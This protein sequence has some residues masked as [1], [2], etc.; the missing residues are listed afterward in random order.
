MEDLDLLDKKIMYELDIDARM[1][2]SQLAKKLRKSK[3][4]INFRI[5]RLIKSDYLKGF[6]TVFNT[7]A[8]GWFYV[9]F[10]F[11]FR[12]IT[13][14]K[15][16]ELFE[17]I[18]KQ[19]HIAYLGSVEGKY[20]CIL[21]VMVKNYADLSEF[22]DRFM[23][24]YGSF[25]R[26][27]DIVTFLT[28]HRL[29]ERFLFEGN[30]KKDWSYPIKLENYTLD[31]LDKKILKE[32][33]TNART[34][35][36]EI[37][38]RL[39][40]DPKVIN[41]RLKKLEKDRIILAYVTA[42]NFDKLGKSFFQVNISLEDPT[43]RPTVIEFFN[44]TNKCLYAIEIMGKY[45]LLVE[46]HLDGTAELKSLLDSFREKFVN[47]YSDYDVLTVSKEHVVVWSPFE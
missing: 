7:S 3:E 40:T 4:T 10:Y 18:S 46:L 32:I 43:Q 36:V 41:Y 12:S 21:L 47:V 16:K 31:K 24:K 27:K 19:N 9:K 5:N 6:Y 29:N 42:P 45:D 30:E 23:K 8:L 13:P 17:Y 38:S 39:E 20:D 2:A 33:S 11:K 26:E 28:T 15:E 37:A 35:I 1:P 22:Q 25:I 14:L 44:N 34:P